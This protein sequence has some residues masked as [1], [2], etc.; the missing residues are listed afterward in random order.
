[1][2]SN[3]FGCNLSEAQRRVKDLMTCWSAAATEPCGDCVHNIDT[4]SLC[5]HAALQLFRVWLVTRCCWNAQTNPLSNPSNRAHAAGGMQESD[6]L[7][8]AH[9]VHMCSWYTA[10]VCLEFSGHSEVWTHFQNQQHITT[11]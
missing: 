11:L 7:R 4:R 8:N 6:Q 2:K 3:I 1:M 10:C 5:W 9:R